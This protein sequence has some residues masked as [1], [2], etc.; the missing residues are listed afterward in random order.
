M[1]PALSKYDHTPTPMAMRLSFAMLTQ[2]PAQDPAQPPCDVSPVS[3]QR[4]G[5]PGVSFHCE[6]GSAAVFFADGQTVTVIDTKLVHCTHVGL[7][8]RNRKIFGNLV[9]F[10]CKAAGC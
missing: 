10:C 9:E 6:P 5:G 1:Q 8:G 2:D 7:A 3:P 4:N